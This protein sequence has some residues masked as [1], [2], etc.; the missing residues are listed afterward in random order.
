[1]TNFT[2]SVVEDAALAW[3]E[4]LGYVVKHGPEIAPGELFAE[5]GDYGQVILA[6]RLREALVRLNPALPAEA[7][8]DAFRKIIRLE[9]ATLDARNR[10]FHRLLVDGVTVEYR[11]ESAIRGAQARLIDFDNPDNND[12]IA[13]NQFTVLEDE[14]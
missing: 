4:S 6:T 8:D 9:G 13:V 1:M 11:A 10:T 12:W 5:R 14:D 3:L 2:E 7:I